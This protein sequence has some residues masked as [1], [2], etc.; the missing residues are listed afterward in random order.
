M[1]NREFCGWKDIVYECV[2]CGH[3]MAATE[4]NNAYD[5]CP[6]CRHRIE[7]ED[8]LTTEEIEEME[9]AAKDERTDQK[10]RAK[11][12]SSWADSFK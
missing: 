2:Y 6:S 4:A 9:Q 8:H 1:K 3:Q 7:W 11:S 10:L 5:G 12:I